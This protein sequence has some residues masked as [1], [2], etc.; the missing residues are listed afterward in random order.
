MRKALVTLNVGDY[1]KEIRQVTY[2]L[3]ATWAAKIG[4]DFIEIVQRKYP[5]YPPA[6]EKLQCADV[7]RSGYDWVV[8]MDA[9]AMVHPDT[10]DWTAM[11]NK[12]TVACFGFDWAPVRWTID[13]PFLRDGRMI[14]WANWLAVASD[15]TAD[16][17]W[18]ELDIPYAVAIE[19]IH[20]I[21]AERQRKMDPAHL[22]DDYTLSRNV[23]R[24]GLKALGLLEYMARFKQDNQYF[25]FH[26]YDIPMEYRVS[27]M[28]TILNGGEYMTAAGEKVKA[29]GWHL[30]MSSLQAGRSNPPKPWV[31]P[32]R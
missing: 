17:L 5:D 31:I 3:M 18:A 20:P 23:A 19:R 2:P 16:A 26:R 10:P 30:P 28:Q 32:K 7:A 24:F 12:D 14:G 27:V 15:W 22:L 4:A 21:A 11:M 8:F 13:G 9:D 29:P 25:Y 6:Y 1:A